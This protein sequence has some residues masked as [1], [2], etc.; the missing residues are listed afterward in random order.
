[1]ITIFPCGSRRS[2]GGTLKPLRFPATSGRGAEDPQTCRNFR[3][4]QM[5]V[6]IQN[7]TTRRVRSGPKMSENAQFQGRM[8][9]PTEHLHP[10]PQNQPKTPFCG[11]FNAKPIIQRALSKSHVNGAT[12][13]KLTVLWGVSKFFRYGASGRHRAP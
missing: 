1:M 12:K 2:K 11:P 9:F 4:W 13:L 7:T 8:Y 5:T 6:P 3:L 10:Y